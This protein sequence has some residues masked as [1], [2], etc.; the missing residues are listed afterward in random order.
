MTQR[1]TT[2]QMFLVMPSGMAEPSRIAL[3]LTVVFVLISLITVLSGAG[4]GVV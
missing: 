3:A 1:N 2:A 4:F